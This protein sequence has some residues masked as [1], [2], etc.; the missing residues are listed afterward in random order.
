MRKS[1]SIVLN[2]HRR[3]AKSLVVLLLAVLAVIIG[4]IITFRLT[5]QPGKKQAEESKPI[6][7]TNSGDS[8]AAN[9][10]APS[11]DNE[12]DATQPEAGAVDE[13]AG[14]DSSN[15]SNTPPLEGKQSSAGLSQETGK[16]TSG[17]ATE[18]KFDTGGS[19][20]R[21]RLIAL[22]QGGPYLL[23]VNI[24]IGREDLETTS[25]RLINEISDE[26]KAPTADDKAQSELMSAGTMGSTT[27][28]TATS[29]MLDESAANLADRQPSNQA[30]RAE[31][32]WAQL[33]DL[34]LIQSGWLGN[35]VADDEQEDQLIGMYDVQRDDIV[36]DDELEQFLSRGLSRSGALQVTETGSAT[37]LSPWGPADLDADF[38]LSEEEAE[39]MAEAIRELDR[40][41]DG[42]V[43]R[44]EVESSDDPSAM[45]MQSGLL[46]SRSL[47]VVDGVAAEEEKEESERLKGFANPAVRVLQHYTFLSEVPREQWS[48]WRDAQWQVLDKDESGSV[49]RYEMQRLVLAPAHAILYVR[50]PSGVA[51]STV[52]ESMQASGGS[53]TE[54]PPREAP[55][56]MMMACEFLGRA[57][58]ESPVPDSS[59]P[60]QP[61]SEEAGKKEAGRI[62]DQPASFSASAPYALL[63]DG[64][65]VLELEI[66]DRF[67]QSTRKS[68]RRSIEAA[69]GNAQ[70]R[71]AVTQ[72]LSVTTEGLMLADSNGDKKLSEIEMDSVW[73]WMSARQSARMIARWSLVESPWFVLLDTDGSRSLDVSELEGANLRVAALDKDRSQSLAPNE[74]PLIVRLSIDRSDTRM[75]GLV[76]VLPT[77]S[78][79]QTLP[80]DW[81]AAMDLNGDSAIS[82]DEFLGDRSDFES[83]DVDGD[84]VIR[85]RDLY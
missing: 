36:A 77:E 33:L 44:A 68:L 61:D 74:L 84:G 1:H 47:F 19:W 81:F 9:T 6:F 14:D 37:G 82:T 70:A 63:R 26:L 8:A 79:S 28:T 42:L 20:T 62:E 22:T 57:Q 41:G 25:S 13:A 51:E 49:D 55:A 78:Q 45:A 38:L 72:Q 59:D 23:D 71:A 21:R 4:A 15:M 24:A 35:L 12:V 2:Q 50:F 54:D 52:T 31:L 64:S 7:K 76:N 69:L 17:D 48:N 18:V 46:Q 60:I 5:S 29:A 11:E 39:E 66:A 73:R 30:E 40:D 27:S 67:S 34:P 56:I 32:S 85:R 16:Q 80:E 43:T 3:Q 58:S 10:E 75:E 65:I 83:L 53:A